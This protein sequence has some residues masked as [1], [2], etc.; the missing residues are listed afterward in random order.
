MNLITSMLALHLSPNK[1]NT[2][3]RYRFF[4]I[5]P[6]EAKSMDPQQRLLLHA[7]YE[8]LED[9]GYVPNAT[10]TSDPDRFGCYIGAATHDYLQN[11]GNDVDVYYSTGKLLFAW[12]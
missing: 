7:A 10:A 4:N 5:S 3:F 1:T 11:L 6:R 12:I 2:C 9:S 8:A